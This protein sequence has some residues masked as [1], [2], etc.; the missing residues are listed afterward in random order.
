MVTATVVDDLGNVFEGDLALLP[1]EEPDRPDPVDP[2]P[3]D[4]P[5]LPDPDP[6]DPDD[7]DEPDPGPPEDPAEPDDPLPEPEDPAA[8]PDRP[9]PII[10]NINRDRVIYADGVWNEGSRYTRYQNK[11][12]WYNDV[13]TVRFRCQALGGGSDVALLGSEYTLLLDDEPVQTVSVAPGAT[14]VLFSF[15]LGDRPDGWAIAD[16]VPHGD[17]SCI[18]QPVNILR[19]A[20]PPP[21]KWAPVYSSSKDF[22][23]LFRLRWV[24]VDGEPLPMPLEPR[25]FQPFDYIPAERDLWKESLTGTLASMPRRIVVDDRGVLRTEAKEAYTYDSLWQKKVEVAMLDGERGC[26]AVPYVTHI[27]AGRGRIDDNPGSPLVGARYALTRS[28]L[29]RISKTGKVTTLVGDRNIGGLPHYWNGPMRIE[30]VGN[31]D[32]VPPARRGILDPWGLAIQSASV[33]VDNTAPRIPEEHNR[34]PHVGNPVMFFSSSRRDAIL[35]AEF[36][37]RSHA[38][39]AVVSEFVV[40]RGCWDCVE[41]G[42][43][44][45]V[46]ERENHRITQYNMDTGELERVIASG[47]A[48]AYV[49]SSRFVYRNK[50]L[51]EIRA[52]TVVAPEGLYVVDNWLYF[53]SAAMGAVRRIHLI[54]GELQGVRGVSSAIAKADNYWK[55][56]VSRGGVGRKGTVWVT[57]WK[58]RYFGGPFLWEPNAGVDFDDPGLYS[59]QSRRGLFGNDS[60][61]LHRGVGGLGFQ[62]IGYNGAVGC[63]DEQ[64]ALLCGSS[65]EGVAQFSLRQPGD[66]NYNNSEYGDGRAEW[67]SKGYH[68]KYGEHGQ[69]RFGE[70]LP[71]GESENMDYFLEVCGSPRP[72]IAG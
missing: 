45:I 33:T 10:R 47:R 60:N 61:K 51:N 27:Q 53:A 59:G 9:A 24:P 30:R 15:N 68:F 2:D 32:A 39:P 34:H 3:D 63:D 4:I 44:L 31:W 23:G 8:E 21:Q 37:G 25:E 42:N 69:S 49:S 5:P 50:P 35:R 26:N 6:D 40:Q 64:G 56:A 67:R 1:P 11:L 22:F 13:A 17:E 66:I 48:L 16:V 36:D 14:S 65:F 52:E 38:T 54:T 62:P 70:P 19:G 71:W 18:P 12:D 7:V 41:W 57:N 55:I 29:I 46:S 43:S 20:T 72:M 58:N 28:S